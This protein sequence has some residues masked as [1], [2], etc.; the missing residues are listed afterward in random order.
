[1]NLRSLLI[2]FSFILV[3]NSFRAQV[4]PCLNASAGNEGQ[5]IVDAD[6]NIFMY[7]GNQLE[8]Y[9]KNFNPIWVKK[10]SELSFYSL[11]LSKTGSIYFIASDTINPYL[12]NVIGKLNFDGSL[13]WC[14]I[15]QSSSP[16]NQE[17]FCQLMLDRNN[18]LIAS[19]NAN[20]SSLP[21]SNA[22]FLKL[23]TLGNM[24]LS[25][26]FEVGGGVCFE[27]FV[28]VEDDQGIYRFIG[29]YTFFESGG[30]MA[31]K[32]NEVLD[33]IT[34]IGISATV[35]QQA[36]ILFSKFYKSKY[37]STV[38]FS[39]HRV[40]NYNGLPYGNIIKYR[41]D[42]IIWQLNLDIPNGYRIDGF[43]EDKFG[44]IFYT[45]SCGYCSSYALANTATKINS[46]CTMSQS[47][48]YFYGY[49][50]SPPINTSEI[51][52]KIH[53]L[54]SNNYFYDLSGPTF[55][56]NPLY[57][58][59]LDS[60]LNSLCATGTSNSISSIGGWNFMSQNTLPAQ[61]INDATT[62]SNLSL[63]VS[64]ITSFSLNTNY[65]VLTTTEELG[66]KTN[67]ISIHP[68]PANNILYVL[69]SNDLKEVTVFDVNGKIILLQNQP[70]AIDI[71]NLNAGIYFIKIKTDQGEFSQK[72]IKE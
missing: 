34:S 21:C 12:Q 4:F 10:Y 23:D 63:T 66:K 3:V 6:T 43:D 11:L 25:K 58:T 1:M 38:Y 19:G 46:N 37:D 31:L 14:K 22:W 26:R 69:N 2:A 60:N 13:S 49:M 27:K 61:I 53:Y 17:K 42:S 47:V 9:D 62:Y 33:S 39:F 35:G 5:Y 40:F 54:H 56:I 28:V 71:A 70:T 52:G 7:H 55:S 44:N 32:Y 51:K 15:Y 50:F 36:S 8:K 30:L 72:F 48:Q 45:I 18:N 24:L 16:S 29:D 59:P 57:V 68:N 20:I 65:C 67:N 41:N 64:S